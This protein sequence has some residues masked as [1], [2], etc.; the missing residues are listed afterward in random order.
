MMMKK[1]NRTN[2]AAAAA[3][4]ALT[5]VA[6]LQ[7]QNTAGSAHPA[8]AELQSTPQ[9]VVGNESALNSDAQM[10]ISKAN[11]ASSLI[12]M[13]VRN[14]QNEKLGEIKD[15]V[16][17]LPTGKVAYAVL[18]VG[19]FLGV[20]DKYIAVPPGAFT[21]APDQ[22][23]VVLNADKARIQNA[24]GFAKSS[25]PDANGTSWRSDAAYWLPDSTAQGTAGSTR[26]GTASEQ[27]LPGGV[28]DQTRTQLNTDTTRAV[29]SSSVP[30]TAY[31]RTDRATSA[32]GDSHEQFRGTIK[33]VNPETRTMTVEGPSGTRQFTF[34][35]TPAIT[36]QDN[37]NPRLVDLKVGYPVSVGF[38]EENGTYIA[39]S[40]IRTDAPVIK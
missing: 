33:A 3:V 37:R 6:G 22:Q 10:P 2:L 29:T 24:P 14:A 9:R 11:K 28:P 21:I 1:R 15:L 26:S 38:H 20:G 25:W 16:L 17:D 27:T 18:S 39:H 8:T 31:S 36:L 12:G 23:R 7:A 4:F 40:V 30:A 32:L 5:G 19:G 34:S 35:E 13:D